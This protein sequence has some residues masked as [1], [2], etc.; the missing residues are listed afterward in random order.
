M[1]VRI[2][3]RQLGNEKTQVGNLVRRD[4]A[5]S[6]PMR[7]RVHASGATLIVLFLAALIAV[8]L[9]LALFARM[10]SN[11]ETPV[12]AAAAPRVAALNLEADLLQRRVVDLVS[13]SIEGKLQA[14]EASIQNGQVTATDLQ[15]L[16]ELRQELRILANYGANSPAAADA[17][18]LR[19]GIAV[20]PLAAQAV[21]GAASPA[22]PFSAYFAIALVSV[23]SLLIAG[24]WWH[25]M[26]R[27]RRLPPGSATNRPLISRGRSF[28]VN[29]R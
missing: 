12:Q 13:G 20:P 14:I 11:Y 17:M 2:R 8:S 9:L 29:N 18:S 4:W 21:N 6:A 15:A 7:I 28:T 23:T 24:Y 3:M 26:R 25:S 22:L 19:G 5:F 27:L 10:L 16:D 1:A